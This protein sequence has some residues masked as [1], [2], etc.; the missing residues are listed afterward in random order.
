MP[1]SFLLRH[2]NNGAK[3][4]VRQLPGGLFVIHGESYSSTYLAL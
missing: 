4:P 1:L 2:L 3:K